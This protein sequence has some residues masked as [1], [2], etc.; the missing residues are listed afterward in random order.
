MNESLI[1]SNLNDP[2]RFRIT[3][4]NE[5]DSTN[6]YMMQLGKKGAPEWSVAISEKQTSGRG[7]RGHTW[8]S[9]KG[10]GL[11]F[12][13]L[14]RPDLKP[15]YS[16]HVN[17][18]SAV[19]LSDFLEREIKAKT[20]QQLSIDLKWPNDVLIQNKKLSGILLQSNIISDK[21]NYLIL[22]IGLN[23]NQTAKDFSGH[24]REKAISLKIATGLN[25]NREKLLAGFLESFHK[26]YHYYLANDKIMILDSYLKKVLSMGEIISVAQNGEAVRGI[27]KGLSS[28][29]YL[30]LQQGEKE[31]V[32]TTGEI[33]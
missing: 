23:V 20:D 15:E 25:W 21:I 18:I 9:P 24:L 10:V 14:L 3:V 31:T 12:S 26:D 5:I 1:L 27:F 11:W 30:I 19:C 32:I 22:G 7:R 28:Q 29:G 2:E 6:S 16:H 13:I 4:F 33:I 17:L 8:Q